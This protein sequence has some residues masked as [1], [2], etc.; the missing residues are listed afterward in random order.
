MRSMLLEEFARNIILLPDPKLRSKGRRHRKK[1]KELQALIRELGECG[2]T[3]T[4]QKLISIK[5]IR[6]RGTTEYVAH[7]RYLQYCVNYLRENIH[8]YGGQEDG[9]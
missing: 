5:S 1:I 4:A 2:S 9:S 3:E 8:N 7:L 6:C